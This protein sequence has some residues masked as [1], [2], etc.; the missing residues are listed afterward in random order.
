MH[1]IVEG[2]R[3][4]HVVLLVA[5]QT[6]LRAESSCDLYV[7]AC[8]QSIERVL[9]VFCDR[10]GMRE[11]CNAPAVEWRAQNGF[12]DKSVDTKFHSRY[13]GENSCVKQS[14]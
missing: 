14:E 1:R 6:M 2:R 11:Q 4:D 9:Q 8:G 5:A 10:S 12:G 13:A 7:I 3:L